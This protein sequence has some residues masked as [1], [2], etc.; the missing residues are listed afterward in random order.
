MTIQ[1]H[2]TR[3]RGRR[4]WHRSMAARA[5]WLARAAGRGGA[6]GWVLRE[7]EATEISVT[8]VR[9]CGSTA[10]TDG[11]Q[12]SGDVYSTIDGDDAAALN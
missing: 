12:G 4:A 3:W 1:Q 7:E 2:G 8:W 10:T 5:R 11:E 6:K 9:R